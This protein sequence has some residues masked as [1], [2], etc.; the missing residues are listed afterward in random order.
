MVD[1]K[2]ETRN[3]LQIHVFSGFIL[4]SVTDAS[5]S[6]SKHVI[7][8]L[9]PECCLASDCIIS[10]L[11]LAVSLGL[12]CS[13]RVMS[14]HSNRDTLPRCSSHTDPSYHIH[15][16][17]ILVFASAEVFVSYSFTLPA[18]IS[19]FWAVLLLR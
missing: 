13:I 4:H 19:F 18:L 12:K 7:G 2:L 5:S 14:T 3:L 10:A 8:A 6:A 11:N 17:S 9:L 15:E 1:P 16:R